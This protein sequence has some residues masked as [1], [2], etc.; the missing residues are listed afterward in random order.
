M[1]PEKYLVCDCRLEYVAYGGATEGRKLVKLRG[2]GGWRC[3]VEVGGF[4]VTVTPVHPTVRAME[5]HGH[6]IF[7]ASTQNRRGEYCISVEDGGSAEHQCRVEGE[8]ASN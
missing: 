4:S 1:E 5:S 8:G 6:A 7:L 2:V 3:T